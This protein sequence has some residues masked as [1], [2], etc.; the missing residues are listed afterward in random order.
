MPSTASIILNIVDRYPQFKFEKSD[1]F[2]WSSADSVICYNPNDNNVLVLLLHELSHALLGHKLYLSDIQ[3]LTIERQAW[4]YA[5]NLAKSFNIAI[6]EEIIQSNLDTYRDWQHERSTCPKCTAT[7]MQIKNNI[8]NCL[9][10]GH[11]W[12]VN[13][14]RNCRLQRRDI[15]K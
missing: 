9:A 12:K 8:Y 4:D 7:G 2:L 1:D 11:K 10:C 6:P 15:N 14:A 3:L 5:I 13:Q